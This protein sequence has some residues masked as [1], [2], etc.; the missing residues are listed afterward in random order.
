[1]DDVVVRQARVDVQFAEH[2]MNKYMNKKACW[3]ETAGTRYHR[4]YG[5][6][7]DG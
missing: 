3:T 1:M 4:H 5:A 2:L 6:A 7:V